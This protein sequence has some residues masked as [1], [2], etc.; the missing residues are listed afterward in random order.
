MILFYLIGGQ[1]T[2]A[3]LRGDIKGL[4]EIQK[5]YIHCLPFIYQF[6]DLIVGDQIN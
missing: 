3:M 2:Q 6:C 1:F 5:N 4:A